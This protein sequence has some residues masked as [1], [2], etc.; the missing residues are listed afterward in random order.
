MLGI[1]NEV[2]DPAPILACRS[3]GSFLILLQLGPK[4]GCHWTGHDKNWK[5]HQMSWP[6]PL[7]KQLRQR[8]L[9]TYKLGWFI[10]SCPILTSV[11]HSM[12]VTQVPQLPSVH[13][14][15]GTASGSNLLSRRWNA[16]IQWISRVYCQSFIALVFSFIVTLPLHKTPSSIQCLG[17][18]S[19]PPLARFRYPRCYHGLVLSAFGHG[20]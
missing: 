2:V 3:C 11:R 8:Q 17:G 20:P 10:P 5:S 13:P 7:T 16:T 15:F 9:A 12:V 6:H 19:H 4:M 14:P 18:T 1:A